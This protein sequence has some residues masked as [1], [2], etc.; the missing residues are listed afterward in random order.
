MKKIIIIASIVL[1]ILSLS[2]LGLSLINRQQIAYGTE[3]TGLK[4]GGQNIEEASANIKN[5]WEKFAGESIK[6]IYKKSGENQPE[7]IY[8]WNIDPRDLGFHVDC[9]KTAEKAFA[10]S[11]QGNFL[12]EIKEEWLA[13][14][15]QMEIKPIFVLDQEK[16][17]KE[18]EK[19][20]DNAEEPAKNANLIYNPDTGKFDLE[21]SSQGKIINRQKLIA[22][23]YQRIESFAN[24][25]ISAQEI[26][27]DPEVND[28]EVKKAEEKANIIIENQPYYLKLEED[29][30]KID[31]ELL[32][33]WIKFKAVFEENSEN[34]ILGFSLDYEKVEEYLDK[35]AE[36]IDCSPTNAQLETEGNK[37]IVFVPNQKGFEVKRKQ[38]FDDF[39]ENLLAN[40]P[41]ETT[42]IVADTAYPKITL[43]QT[44]DLGINSLLGRGESN[45]SGSP[46]NR[47]HNI[48]TGIAKLNGI[49]L[50]PGEEF[51]FNNFLGT[52]EA[53]QG[54]LP[55]LVIKKGKLINEYGGGVCQI[56]TTFF[57]A[58]INS[59]LKI[60]ERQ[61]HAFPVVY[62]NPQGFDA[63]VY[64]PKPDLRFINN[65]PN[66]L[67]IEV[68]IQGY[69]ILVNLYGT[70]DNRQIEVKGPYVLEKKEDGSM[71]T[72]LYQKV[73]RD[74]QLDFEDSFYSN[75]G[76]I[77]SE[78]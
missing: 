65:T 64:D 53:E 50:E 75:Y 7:Q 78:E 42:A 74:D 12:N 44:N 77:P 18:T 61:N 46:K 19:L 67:L 52:T 11:R 9:L 69:K 28:E 2:I 23:I 27:Q 29:Y 5:Q 26:I 34:K 70:E 63:T 6:I 58:A 55:E 68:L 22:D 1:I 13:F 30:H 76:P 17:A 56:S 57:R 36:K 41:I 33:E 16:F 51:S 43:A 35:I 8:Q 48:K 59:G 72:V 62:Y 15:G 24:Q 10:I 21:N 4:V 49:I 66:H 45:F 38:T 20:F 3:I 71:K 39:I 32:L 14:F 54:F 47:I 31:K 73:Y 60:V 25:P 37:A 40:P